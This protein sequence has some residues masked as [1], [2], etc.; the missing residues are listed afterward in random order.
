MLNVKKAEKIFKKNFIGPVQLKSVARR[1]NII[2]PFSLGKIPLIRISEKEANK[3]AKDFILVLG[4]PRDAKGKKLTINAMRSFFGIDPK[5]G[6][7]CFYNQDWYLKERFASET[8]LKFKWYLI[9]KS[10]RNQTR[11]KAPQ[12][13][14]GSLSRKEKFPS[15]I[16]TAFTFFAYWFCNK[17]EILWKHDFIWCN[18]K[19][20]NGDRIYT[21]RYQDPNHINK[22]GFNIHRHLSIKPCYGAVVQMEIE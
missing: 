19:D 4:V 14:L 12:E 22:N 18:D 16:L 11:G 17:R 8:M 7:P 1:M 10:V 6:E 2:N 5:E 21:G 9:R 13:I 3:L 20:K 15:A